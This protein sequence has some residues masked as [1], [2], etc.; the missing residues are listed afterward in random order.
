MPDNDS[1]KHALKQLCHGIVMAHPEAI[2]MALIELDCGCI[3]VC[4]VSVSGEPVGGMASFSGRP[5]A[6]DGSR[7]ICIQCAGAG[8]PMM[9]RIVHQAL[10]WPG[11]ATE[12]PDVELR[13]LIGRAVFG[14]DYAEPK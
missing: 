11:D 6:S 13:N 12:K 7:P 4:G 3:N 1:K 8:A 14:P 5:A 9:E 2:C 10:V